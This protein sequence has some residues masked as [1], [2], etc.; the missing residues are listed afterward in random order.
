[1]PPLGL[2]TGEIDFSQKYV[3]LRGPT[4]PGNY[5]TAD[6]LVKAGAVLVRYGMLVNAIV[7]FILVATAVFFMVQTVQRMMK[8]KEEAPPPPNKR[9]CPQCLMEIPIK[10][11]RCGHC[12]SEVAAA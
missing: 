8:K 9:E 12:T 11:T 6:E 1:M 7:S 3:M 10:A 2:L 5:P 4:T